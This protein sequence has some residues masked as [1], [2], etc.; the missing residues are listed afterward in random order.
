MVKKAERVSLA[1]KGKERT[2]PRL[3]NNNSR[4]YKEE[5]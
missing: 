1:G 3:Q 4:T 5:K 2:S